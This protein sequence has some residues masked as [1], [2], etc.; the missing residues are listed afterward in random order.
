MGVYDREYF[1]QSPRRESFA[2]VPALSV[3]MWLIVINVAVFFIE[4]IS[5]RTTGVYRILTPIGI[6]M[7]SP[8]EYW[9]HFSGFTVIVEHQI[10]RFITFQFLHAGFAHIA[11]NMF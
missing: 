4:Q 11:F 9:G 8:I 3:T 1:R 10:W 6:I 5:T 2:R 7:M